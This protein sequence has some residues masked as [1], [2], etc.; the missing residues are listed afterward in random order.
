MWTQLSSKASNPQI[1]VELNLVKHHV[2]YGSFE[3]YIIRHPLCLLI[4]FILSLEFFC[5]LFFVCLCEFYNIW[6]R[7]RSHMA[8]H[9]TWIF[10]ITLH[11]FGGVLGR[12]LAVFFWA[13]TISWFVC[14]VAL[15]V[16]N[17]E[18]PNASN[19][20]WSQSSWTQ[21]NNISQHQLLKWILECHR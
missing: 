1:L 12:S 14:E 5:F 20:I 6:V 15:K 17:Y 9:Y 2:I 11:D 8:S 16:P 7:I 13:L 19:W 10:V 18:N 3:C 4:K 21:L